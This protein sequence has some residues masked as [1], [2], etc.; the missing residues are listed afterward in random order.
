MSW[1]L[2]DIRSALKSYPSLQIDAGFNIV[3]GGFEIKNERGEV[4]ETYSLEIT[5]PQSYPNSRLPIVREVSQRIP[6]NKD[7]HIFEDGRLCLSTPL[8]ELL[9]CRDGITF[10]KFLDE[11]LH[12]FL[13]S[14][15]AISC[16]WLNEFPQGEYSHGG[17]GIYESYSEFL[18]IDGIDKAISALIMATKRNQRNKKCFCAS[19]KKLK[20]CHFKS[21]T[22]L[23]KLGKDQL[24][25]DA[26]A[27]LACK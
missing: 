20:D 4:L 9:I 7:R 11:V 15:Y 21:Y 19:R 2:N 17:K 8:G 1:L 25:K 24:Y 26:E 5:I 14:Q 18:E 27:M 10:L 23:Q 13:A 12:P 6:R 22:L 16:G 3:K